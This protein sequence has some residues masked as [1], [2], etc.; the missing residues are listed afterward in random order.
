MIESIA[1]PLHITVREHPL[2]ARK[3]IRHGTDHNSLNCG[4]YRL[5]KKKKERKECWKSWIPID[6]TNSRGL[7]LDVA[8]LY[9]I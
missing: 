6:F 8:L 7:T 3:C 4:N 5:K 9:G 1:F 2:G